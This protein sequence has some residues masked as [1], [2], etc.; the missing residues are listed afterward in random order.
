MPVALGQQKKRWNQPLSIRFHQGSGFRF[1]GI[2]EIPSLT[3]EIVTAAR[4]SHGFAW[5]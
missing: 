2:A 1:D 5:I 3:I 4:Q